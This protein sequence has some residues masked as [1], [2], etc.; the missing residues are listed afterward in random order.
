MTTALGRIS[1]NSVFVSELTR[2]MKQ[3][4]RFLIDQSRKQYVYMPGYMCFGN[5]N[6]L[7]A[8]YR[9]VSLNCF[10]CTGF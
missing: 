7:P 4:S 1:Q 9:A 8:H 5:L 2:Q 6:I 3:R 10:I